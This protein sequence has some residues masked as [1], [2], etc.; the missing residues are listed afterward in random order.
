MNYPSSMSRGGLLPAQMSGPRFTEDSLQRQKQINTLMVFNQ[1]VSE[2]QH[3]VHY[4]VDFAPQGTPLQLQVYLSP[5]FPR[6]RPHILLSPPCTHPWLDA[7]GSVVG[8]PGL[9]NYSIHSDLGRVV[10]A[11]K[12]EMEKNPPVPQPAS[13]QQTQSKPQ[14][15]HSVYQASHLHNA[16]PYQ[17]AAFASGHSTRTNG[18]SAG[19]ARAAPSP[20]ESA[21]P[22]LNDLSEKELK[23]LKDN[24]VAARAFVRS[25][26]NP[27]VKRLE[28]EAADRRERIATLLKEH[29]TDAAALEGQRQSLIEKLQSVHGK[30]EEVAKL[31][32]DL[33][34]KRERVSVPALCD[35]LRKT[36]LEKEDESDA[37]AES[38]LAGEKSLD[39]FLKEYLASR[40]AMHL[41]KAKL[42][43]LRT[44]M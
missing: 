37:I 21:I 15:Q 41:K 19:F 24:E 32:A 40:S 5:N 39:N 14:S 12:M 3:G 35:L 20:A 42:D 30:R 2:V 31:S 8:A 13:Q 7:N 6:E 29:E 11:I 38:F 26:P 34:R 44:S 4:R 18:A 17:S 23:E 28:K 36:S 16:Y 27:T 1:N 9:L 25:L 10:Q 22:G 33:E 43:K